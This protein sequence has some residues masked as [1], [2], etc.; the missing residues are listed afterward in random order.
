MEYKN[1]KQLKKINSACQII[2]LTQSSRH[3][4][5]FPRSNR[6]MGE[7]QIIL[8]LRRGISNSFFTGNKPKFALMT[9]G[10][11]ILTIFFFPKSSPSPNHREAN[12]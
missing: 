11:H 6:L 9:G 4:I 10:K 5:I 12:T 1:I 3:I 7:N 2:N 8:K